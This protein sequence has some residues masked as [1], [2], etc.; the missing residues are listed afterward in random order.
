MRRVSLPTVAALVCCLSVATIAL[1]VQN[2]ATLGRTEP[3]F[4][5]STIYGVGADEC[6]TWVPSNDRD[7]M[8]LAQLSWVQGFVSGVE[9]EENSVMSVL[10]A[11]ETYKPEQERREIKLPTYGI[12]TASEV[13]RWMSEYCRSHPSEQISAAAVKLFR[14]IRDPLP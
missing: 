12:T 13:A 5:H 11:A 2:L 6:S 3:G 10:S 14:Q 4:G 9:Q 8:S 7:V 1:S